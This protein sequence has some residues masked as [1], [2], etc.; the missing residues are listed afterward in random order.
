MKVCTYVKPGHLTV[1]PLT[2]SILS[3]C[4]HAPFSIISNKRETTIQSTKVDGLAS[5][6][7]QHPWCH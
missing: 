7:K 6:D 4:T 1:F 3:A 2:E 5:E